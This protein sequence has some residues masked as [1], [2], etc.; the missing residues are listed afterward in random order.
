VA[1]AAGAPL[2]V[3]ARMREPAEQAYFDAEIRPHLGRDVEFLGGVSGADK[4]ALLG[5]ARALLMPIRWSEPFGMVMIESLACGTPVLA[6]QE[7]APPEVVEHGRTGLLCSDEGQMAAADGRVNELSR[8]AC[9]EAVAS[10]FSARRMA[11]D[12]IEVYR[13]VLADRLAERRERRARPQ[14]LH[15]VRDAGDLDLAL[16]IDLDVDPRVT[17]GDPAHRQ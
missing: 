7:G 8:G 10:R 5:G 17:E 16:R 4:L 1:Q 9:R 12:H 11:T 13:S 14:H 2:R 3:A 6:F 15:P